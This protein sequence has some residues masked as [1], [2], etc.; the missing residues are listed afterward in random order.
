MGEAAVGSYFQIMEAEGLQSA[1]AHVSLDG[2][3]GNFL[4]HYGKSL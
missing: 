1:L 3:L 2:K 4:R